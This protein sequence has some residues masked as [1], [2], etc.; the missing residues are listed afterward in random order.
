MKVL[1]R[2]REEVKALLLWDNAPAHPT[3]LI[4]ECGKIV[5]KFLPPNSTSLIQPQDQGIISSFKRYYRK[6]FV[7]QCLTIGE[8]A[9]SRD[10]LSFLKKYNLLD[11]IYNCSSAWNDV[12]EATLKNCWNKLI[13]MNEQPT[14][15]ES[16]TF[17]EQEDANFFSKHL[18]LDEAELNEWLYNDEEV[19]TVN[20]EEIVKEIDDENEKGGED[21]EDMTQLE[22]NGSNVFDIKIADAIDGIDMNLKLMSLEKHCDLYDG[23]FNVFETYRKELVQKKSVFKKQTKVTEFFQVSLFFSLNLIFLFSFNLFFLF[24]EKR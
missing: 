18:S 10:C 8:D 3:E 23:Y 7:R 24:S 4:S 17:E 20:E 19:C 12:T 2:K 15:G 21:F 5:T 9:T 11:A 1:K 6:R 14:E 22:D 16:S 13:D